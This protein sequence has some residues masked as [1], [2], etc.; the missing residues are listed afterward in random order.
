MPSGKLNI[1][2]KIASCGEERRGDKRELVRKVIGIIK[3]NFSPPLSSVE[4][5]DGRID[6]Q[7][8]ADF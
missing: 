5:Y 1:M 8:K 3:F 6:D 4:A 7:S 2:R